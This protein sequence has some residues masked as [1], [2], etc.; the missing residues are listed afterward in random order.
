MQ[1]FQESTV[2]CRMESERAYPHQ[3][4]M[5][6]TNTSTLPLHAFQAKTTN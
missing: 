1:Q 3:H 4:K 6:Y 2:V 5:K